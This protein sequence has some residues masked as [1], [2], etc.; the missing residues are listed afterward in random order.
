MKITRI[1]RF[2]AGIGIGDPLNALIYDGDEIPQREHIV[3]RMPKNV[4]RIKRPTRGAIDYM[5]RN[6]EKWGVQL[7]DGTIIKGVFN[8]KKEG[9]KEMA[10]N[11]KGHTERYKIVKFSEVLSNI[12]EKGE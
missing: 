5:H 11:Y 7:V 6:L 2:L 4:V 10:Y 8:S 3:S 12:K 1:K 9:E